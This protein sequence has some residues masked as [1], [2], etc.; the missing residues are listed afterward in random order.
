MY[1][2]V[3]FFGAAAAFIGVCVIAFA[4]AAASS[5]DLATA[6]IA[7]SYGAS[8]LLSGAILWCFGAIVGLLTA[9]RDELFRRPQ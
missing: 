9:I 4:I 7:A 1:R 6:L 8:A 2:I 3:Q 5:N